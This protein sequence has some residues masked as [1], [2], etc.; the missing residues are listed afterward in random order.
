MMC[1]M[2][3]HII[4]V[5]GAAYYITAVTCGRRRIF[6]DAAN[7][8][9]ALEALR[10][11]RAQHALRLYAYVVMP[12]HVHYIMAPCGRHTAG[13]VLRNWKTFTSKTIRREFEAIHDSRTLAALACAALHRRQQAFKVW[14]DGSWGEPLV[15]AGRLRAKIAYIHANPVRAGLVERETDYAWSSARAYAD[16]PLLHGLDPLPL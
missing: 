16:D 3:P 10:F 9:I 6:E 8:Q 5:P 11:Q 4:T 15:D 14:Q 12:D 7:C 2:R 1:S 13:D